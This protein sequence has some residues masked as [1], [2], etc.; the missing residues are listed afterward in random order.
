MWVI[1]VEV[2]QQT[3][4]PPPKRN[5]GSAPDQLCR[6]AVSLK[7]KQKIR[8]LTVVNLVVCLSR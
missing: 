3:S 2:E 6:P 1:G 4:A 5:P 7:T 8:H